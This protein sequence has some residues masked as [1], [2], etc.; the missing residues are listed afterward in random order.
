VN[1]YMQYIQGVWLNCCLL[2]L[3]MNVVQLI[4]EGKPVNFCTCIVSRVVG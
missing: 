4:R 2:L 3:F 1:F